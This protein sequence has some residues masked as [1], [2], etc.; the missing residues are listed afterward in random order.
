MKYFSFRFQFQCSDSVLE[1]AKDLL[2][3][4]AADCGF[5][6]FEDTA[7]AYIGYVQQDLVDEELLLQLIKTFPVADVVITYKKEEIVD[8]NW[9]TVWEQQG[10]EPINIDDKIIV[11]DAKN[12]LSVPQNPNC[13]HIGI[14]VNQAF[15]TGTHHTTQMMIK[16]LST[17]DLKG[18]SVLDCG[19]GTGILGIAA[20]KLG[21]NKVYGFDIDE[22]SVNNSRHNADLNGVTN[23]EILHGTAEVIRHI[24]VCFDVVLANIN[25]NILLDDM[26]EYVAS[27]ADGAQMAISGFYVEDIPLLL[28]KAKTLGLVETK[29]FEQEN[30]ACVILE[31]RSI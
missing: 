4:L 5:E 9:N 25:R 11:Y 26:T 23:L 16:A 1:I 24:N 15:G 30:W 22:W 20:S 3:D 14:D 10:F 21:A 2:A 13:I 28:T 19:C 29:R 31:K 8:Q 17:M 27:M 12:M 7:D 6:S 18:K